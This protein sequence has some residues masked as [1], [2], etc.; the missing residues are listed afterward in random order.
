[1]E[2]TRHVNTL[3]IPAL[4]AVASMVPL[5]GDGFAPAPRSAIKRGARSGVRRQREHAR[6]RRQRTPSRREFRRAAPGGRPRELGRAAHRDRLQ[7]ALRRE[8]GQTLV[9]YGLMFSLVAIL[10]MMFFSGQGQTVLG[11][12]GKAL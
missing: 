4:P 11:N 7:T 12:I 2:T 3:S 8:R 9:E 6:T 10:T 1:V 5:E